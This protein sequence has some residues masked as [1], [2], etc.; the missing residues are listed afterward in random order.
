MVTPTATPSTTPSLVTFTNF[1]HVKHTRDNYPTWLPQIVP[2]LKGG[3]LFGYVDGPF[4]C[5]SL[6]ITT[7]K[8]GAYFT[9]ANLAFLQ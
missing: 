6:V 1:N 8:D 7:S 2:H 4:P 9:Q 5:P 3:N